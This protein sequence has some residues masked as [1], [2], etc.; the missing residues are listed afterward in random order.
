MHRFLLPL[1]LAVLFSSPAFAQTQ[2]AQSQL[3]VPAQKRGA[4]TLADSVKRAFD[5]APELRAAE[6]G[7][8]A[9]SGDLTQAGAWPNPSVELSGDDRL[10][11]EDGRG[12]ADLTRIALTQP[13]PLRRVA[14]E[15][16]VA[17]ANLDSAREGLRLRRLSLELETAR[18][19]HALQAAAAKRRIAAEHL[20]HVESF[21]GG[22]HKSGTDRLVRYLAPLERQRLTILI[23]DARQIVAATDRE[24]QGALINYRALLALPADASVEVAP[25]AL[26]AAPASLASLTQAL[27]AHPELAV[28][29]KEAEAARAGVAVA[30]SQRLA[31]PELN[32]FRERDY[33]A[34][35]RRDVTGIG[36]SVQIP[37]WNDGG[38]RVARANAE[39]GRAQANLAVA[40]RD[41]V[42]RLAEAHAQL[43]RLLNQAG[44][45]RASLLEPARAMLELARRSFATGELNVLSLVDAAN[46]YFDAQIRYLELQR[47]S[48]LAEAGLRFAAGIPLSDVAP[49][50]TR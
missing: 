9:R 36:V 23:E 50:S 3:E 7:I 13:L 6:A 8:A 35:G 28:A 2:L 10:G 24:W 33:L 45:L 46:T 21:P 38:G 12:G 20:Q 44:R 22:A 4:W 47:E 37:L 14:R 31:D 49:G 32:L 41:A 11:Q 30:E 26:P 48:A 15:R 43:S 39:T 25:L 16:A 42:S 27:D 29:R 19:F 40:Q 18:A 1:G 5:V 34:G 17:E